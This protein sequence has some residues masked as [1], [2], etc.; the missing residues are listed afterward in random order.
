VKPSQ[1]DS[2]FFFS[3]PTRMPSD[4]LLWLI[5][6]VRELFDPILKSFEHYTSTSPPQLELHCV[7]S[8][9]LGALSAHECHLSALYSRSNAT[10]SLE[11]NQLVN[12]V[13]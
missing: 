3:M 12:F 1:V 5:D 9:W 10:M 6:Q 2:E 7:D 13:T 4:F 11:H 8:Q